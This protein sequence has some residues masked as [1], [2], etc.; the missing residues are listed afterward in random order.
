MRIIG[1]GV[2]V[3]DIDRAR[4]LFEKERTLERVFTDNEINASSQR[5]DRLKNLAGWFALKEAVLKSL[6]APRDTGI[7]LQ[8]IEVLHG[9]N[10]EPVCDLHGKAR[11]IFLDSGGEELM[12][13]VSHSE[14]SAVGVAI[15]IGS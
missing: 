12:V 10:G 6:K 1:I 8:D 3:I 5:A 13:S 2:D 9:E 15:C 11:D 14:K 7:L 4:E